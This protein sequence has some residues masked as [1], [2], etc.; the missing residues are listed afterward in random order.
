MDGEWAPLHRV[1]EDDG[2]AENRVLSLV[3]SPHQ[4]HKVSNQ[5]Y[6]H[7]SLLATIEDTLRVGRLGQAAGVKTMTA[8]TAP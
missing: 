3:V 2:S 1:G 7:Y 8:L 6:T 4:S 5:A